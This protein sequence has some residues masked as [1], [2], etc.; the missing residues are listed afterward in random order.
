MRSVLSLWSDASTTSLNV[1]GAAVEA[2]LLPALDLEPEL[3][4]DHHPV[5]DGREGLADELLVGERPVPLGGVEKR[6]PEIDGRPDDSDPLL[7][8][9]GLAVAE[10]KAHAAEP[11]GRDF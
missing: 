3:G 5:A 6:A 2:R 1:L 10:T 4:G 8:L 9:D 7:F 11:E